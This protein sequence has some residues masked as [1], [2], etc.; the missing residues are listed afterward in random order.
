VSELRH[1]PRA[2]LAAGILAAAAAAAGCGVT[3]ERRGLSRAQFVASADAVCRHEQ[4][5]LAFIQARARQLGR[6][7]ASHA[8]IRQQAAQRQLATA[9]LERLPEPPSDVG[10]IKRWLT[11]RTVAATVALDL[12]EAPASGSARAVAD[13]RGE[14]AVALARARALAIAYGSQVCGET[15]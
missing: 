6:S 8:V 13:V 14:L 1:Q 4:A 9:R 5:K 12:A 15:D 11:A 3:P 2:V 7:P 10:A